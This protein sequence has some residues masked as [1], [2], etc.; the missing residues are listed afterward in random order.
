MTR[1]RG[2]AAAA[3]PHEA[4]ATHRLAVLFG[5]VVAFGWTYLLA[6]RS[7]S[8]ADVHQDLITIAAEWAVVLVLA[9]IAFGIQRKT[10]AY[11]R[12]RMFGGRDLL[13]MLLAFGATFLLVGVAGRF[14][15]M[16]TSSLDVRQLG[17]VPFPIRLGLVFTAAVCEEFMYRGFGIEEINGLIGSWWIAG[18]ISWAAFTLAHI[19]RYGWTPALLIPAIAGG[20]LTIVY[21]W[22]RNLPVCMLMHF[23]MDGLSI[24]VVPFFLHAR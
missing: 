7:Q 4:H 20:L 9:V 21:L 13:L 16:P 19:D 22:R 24:L 8:V 10:P 3:A 17:A 1:D 2:S 11:F 12:L 6:G 5:L 18:G 23:M 14:V 15:T